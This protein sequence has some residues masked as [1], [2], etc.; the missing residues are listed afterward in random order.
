M[1]TA[2]TLPTLGDLTQRLK[3]WG[4]RLSVRPRVPGDQFGGALLMADVAHLYFHSPCFDGI[5]SAVLVTDFFER[6]RGSPAI[7]LHPVNY[8]ARA[9][10][11]SQGLVEP[12]GVVDFLY[13][14]NATFWADHH[15]TTFLDD[16]QRDDYQRR[17]R[18]TLVYDPAAGSC[19]GLLWNHLDAK[20]AYRN[21]DHQPLVD[22]AERI[23]A[24]RYGSVAE[25]IESSSPALRLNLGLSL[26]DAAAYSVTL[27]RLLRHRSLE[28]ITE[29]PEPRRRYERARLM[30]EAGLA[31]FKSAA[32]VE[33]DGLVV[34]DVDGRGTMISRYAPFYFFPESRYSIGIV[35][36]ESQAR[37]TAMRN[38]WRNFSS[39][40]LGTIFESFGGGGHQ[41]VAALVL[42]K[43]KAAAATDI[44][45][46][47]ISELRR[48][49][50]DHD[51]S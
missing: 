44:L 30:M 10:W 2:R 22:W 38:P 41:R 28:E 29:L 50:R 13:H 45:F 24:A 27:V 21:K 8:D 25:V 49:E 48:Y 42:P 40:P 1:T 6:G 16:A 15:I 7:E 14:H 9:T 11:L 17:K 18:D 12:F 37:I 5:V 3:D 43:D 51:Q 20:V 47:L 39:A 4:R 34:F 33:E 19:A 32:H 23:D 46:G 35:R 31:R 26:G 36:M